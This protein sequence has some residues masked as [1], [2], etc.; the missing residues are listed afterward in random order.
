MNPTSAEI[1]RVYR[2]EAG[3]VLAS[4][5][6]LLGGFELA[7][8]ALH[9][10]FAA[11]AAQWPRDGVPHNPR[12]WLVSAGRFK[13]IDRLR[14][15]RRF[16]GDIEPELLVRLDGA[17]EEGP[18][19]DETVLADDTLRLIFVCCHPELPPD[20]RVALTLREV[21]GL[22]TE[23]IARAFLVSTPALAQRI[24]RAKSRIKALALPYVVPERQELPARRD[25]VLKVIYLVYNEGYAHGRLDIAEEAI[26]LGRLLV[27]LLP[28]GEVLGLLALM[29]LHHARRAARWDAAGDLVLHADQDR[30]LWDLPMIAEGEGLVRRALALQRP[31][32]YA[33][34]AA[35]AAL[36][37][38]DTTD[39]AEI[40]AL[41]ELLGRLDVSPVAALN[42]AVALGFARGFE[43]GLAAIEALLPQLAAYQPAHVARADFLR[44]LGRRAEA[45][46]SYRRALSLS[47][48]ESE[49]R[50]VSNR[51]REV[52]DA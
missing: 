16:R 7:E 17:V 27:E 10:A 25:A 43:P 22:A 48:D 3:R 29:L 6:R 14:R 49:K 9:D 32:A 45:A 52:S 40:L 51:L 26:R 12:A 39:W 5:V 44:R 31:G 28:D 23:E 21:C 38:E 34:Q 30:A 37:A 8:E 42:R 35:I 1:E 11:A 41:H 15:A 46:E 4:L 24:V 33:L 19:M 36:H 50:F 20:A 13:A 2:A 47:V 18:D